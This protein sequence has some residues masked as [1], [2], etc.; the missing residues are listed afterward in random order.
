MYKT[1]PLIAGQFHKC[2]FILVYNFKPGLILLIKKKIKAKE[3]EKKKIPS[4]KP[5]TDITISS[6]TPPL[7][8]NRE[9]QKP[10]QTKT[11][12]ILGKIPKSI[13]FEGYAI[14]C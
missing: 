4:G 1:I 9:R 5:S 6:A 12:Y 13:Y 2:R 14:T 7:A 3:G 10:K 11:G 8:N